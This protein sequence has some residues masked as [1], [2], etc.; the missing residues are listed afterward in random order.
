MD[1]KVLEPA[2]GSGSFLIRAYNELVNYFE[3][4]DKQANLFTKFRIL[5]ANI[6]G[7]DLDA[8]AV[9]IAQ[10]NLLLKTL[11]TKARLPNLVGK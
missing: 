9:E 6:Y 3:K 2:C 1:L 4:K 5:T 8:Q 7:V 11:S 10:L